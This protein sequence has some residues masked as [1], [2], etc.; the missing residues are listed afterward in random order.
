LAD[1]LVN[2]TWALSQRTP[3]FGTFHAIKCLQ[4]H[5]FAR[6]WYDHVWDYSLGML[7]Y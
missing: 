1:S 7:G 2:S 4:I 3:N 6:K 5:I